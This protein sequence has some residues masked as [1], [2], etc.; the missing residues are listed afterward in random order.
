MHARTQM[1]KHKHGQT[2]TH[3][4]TDARGDTHPPTPLSPHTRT[5]T[6]SAHTHADTRAR[7]PTPKHTQTHPHAHSVTR[8]THLSTFT[9]THIHT[10]SR[11]RAGAADCRT[12]QT[13]T[14]LAERCRSK[15]TLT[16][17]ET[18]AS[19]KTL[20]IQ[21]ALRRVATRHSDRQLAMH[22]YG[23]GCTCTSFASI[24]IHAWIDGL[25]CCVCTKFRQVS[26]RIVVC[27]CLHEFEPGR[28]NVHMC[29]CT[30]VNV[31]VHVYVRVHVHVARQKLGA[32]QASRSNGE[33]RS[34]RTLEGVYMCTC[35]LLQL[36]LYTASAVA[37][38]RLKLHVQIL[39]IQI[40][41]NGSHDVYSIS[42]IAIA[43]H[44]CMA[45]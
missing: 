26:V 30:H 14:R 36:Q 45:I 8:P 41:I 23:R 5:H 31:R 21:L 11:V 38:A 4:N 7:T 40:Y 13:C 18:V 2:Y 12:A 20:P 3:I 10:H 22:A 19:P 32:L 27:T 17:A 37:R 28:V 39:Y 42:S 44:T 29:V 6:T 35:N 1:H 43:P 24:Y 34:S 9:H 33:T 16:E 15:P 25:G